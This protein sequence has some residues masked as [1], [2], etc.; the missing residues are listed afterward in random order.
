MKRNQSHQNPSRLPNPQT[1]STILLFT[2]VHTALTSVRVTLYCIL[3]QSVNPAPS[4]HS[5]NPNSGGSSTITILKNQ[6]SEAKF[7]SLSATIT[8]ALCNPILKLADSNK[9]AVSFTTSGV[10]SIPSNFN[11]TE[12]ILI[13]ENISS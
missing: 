1:T 11:L 5:I 8:E 7:P 10:T 13:S 6:V 12:L 9:T 3:L 2:S 4:L